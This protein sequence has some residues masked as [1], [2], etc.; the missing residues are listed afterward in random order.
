MF[1][2]VEHISWSLRTSCSTEKA[3]CHRGRSYRKTSLED[4]MIFKCLL[5][6]YSLK[7][8]FSEAH[9]IFFCLVYIHP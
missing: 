4:G 1:Y 8:P 9:L 5:P 7:Y 2:F 3:M 6:Q